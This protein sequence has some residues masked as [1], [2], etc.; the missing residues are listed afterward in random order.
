MPAWRKRPDNEIVNPTGQEATSWVDVSIRALVQEK[1]LPLKQ[2]VQYAV[3]EK[4]GM[5]PPQELP[6]SPGSV[7]RLCPLRYD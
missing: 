2:I 7:R 6:R 1:M 4:L 3:Q 5:F